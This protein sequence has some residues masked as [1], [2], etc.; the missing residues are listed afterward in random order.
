M[1]KTT[2]P[3]LDPIDLKLLALLQEDART[4]NA[5]IGRRVGLVPSAIF[6]RLRKLQKQGVLLGHEA[7]IDPRAVGLG[8]TA[9]VFVRADERVGRLGTAR[10]LAKLPEV[11]E[12]HHVAGEDC[13]LVKVRV[14]DA[15]DLGRLLREKVGVIPSV[16]STRSTIVF[17]TIKETARLPLRPAR[18]RA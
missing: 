17:E 14:V 12:V 13:Y 3:S 5:E 4:P 18:P 10:R 7:R 15:A 6:Q 8:L 1:K 11:Q 16:R 2:P 9:F